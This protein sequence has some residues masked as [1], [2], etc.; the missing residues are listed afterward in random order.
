M[1]M[2]RSPALHRPASFMRPPRHAGFTLI[3]LII[4]MAIIVMISVVAAPSLSSLLKSSKVQEA[5]NIIMAALYR[6]RG[7]A[8]RTRAPVGLF[9]GDSAARHPAARWVAPLSTTL[10]PEGMLEIWSVV[11]DTT[12]NTSPMYRNSAA[13]WT[14]DGFSAGMC[15]PK[16]PSGGS[17]AY[18]GWFPW[19]V[20]TRI[21]ANP[22]A[23]PNDIRIIAGNYWQEYPVGTTVRVF[24]NYNWANGNF[25]QDRIGEIK[26]HHIVFNSN[27][28]IPCHNGDNHTFRHVLIFD[29]AQN[30]Y[31]VVEAGEYLSMARPRVVN[32]SNLW[33]LNN[34]TLTATSDFNTILQ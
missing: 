29:Q 14:E 4:V 26:R 3:E 16:N 5:A 1:T 18:V 30:N 11:N 31:I 25:I 24:K 28:S 20:K 23:L 2:D 8:V 22:I 17:M 19:Y 12:T 9:F 7:E 27:G 33:T 15:T 32:S 6:T 13:S 34:V 21:R 10:P